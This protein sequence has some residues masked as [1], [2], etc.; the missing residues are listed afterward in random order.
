MFKLEKVE[1]RKTKIKIIPSMFGFSKDTLE[2]CSVKFKKFNQL[3]RNYLF[4][5]ITYRLFH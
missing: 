1:E 2:G 3:D 4:D 5:A